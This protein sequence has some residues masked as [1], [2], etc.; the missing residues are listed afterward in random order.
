[1]IYW[2]GIGDGMCGH[3]GT[4]PHRAN[5][6]EDFFHWEALESVPY[7]FSFDVFIQALKARGAPDSEEPEHFW[8]GDIFFECWDLECT[9]YWWSDEEDVI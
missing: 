1:M 9:S 6:K 4:S 5:N 3:I 7:S 8:I 2:K